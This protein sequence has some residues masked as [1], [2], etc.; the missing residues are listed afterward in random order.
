QRDLD[1]VGANADFS[2]YLLPGFM[3]I[4]GDSQS[5][6]ILES[7]SLR[8]YDRS[9]GLVSTLATW[10]GSLAQ[11]GLWSDGRFV[12]VGDSVVIRR[13]DP[14]TK[15]VTIISGNPSESGTSD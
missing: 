2:V 4:S 12:Y 8:R 3:G 6:Y 11:G 13:V 7:F 10:P 9:S 14:A 1:G 5:L 15:E